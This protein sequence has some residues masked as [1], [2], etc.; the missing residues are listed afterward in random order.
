MGPG[1]LSYKRSDGGVFHSDNL[2][3]IGTMN[4]ADRSLALGRSGVASPFC[5]HRSGPQATAKPGTVGC[6]SRC[7]IDSEILVEK[8]EKRL[9]L[10]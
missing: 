3:V 6:T 1:G 7:G 4:I 5:L 2:Y 10:P 8:S 9:G